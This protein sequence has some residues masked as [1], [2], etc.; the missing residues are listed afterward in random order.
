M[1]DP[2]A[3]YKTLGL[4]PVFLATTSKGVINILVDIF[5]CIFNDEL[6][7]VNS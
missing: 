7:R 2:A 3:M 5:V 1:N 6:L 4:P